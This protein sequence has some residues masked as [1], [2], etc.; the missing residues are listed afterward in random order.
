MLILLFRVSLM[1]DAYELPSSQP[2]KVKPL[3]I[4][5]IWSG[6]IFGVLFGRLF[7][8]SVDFTPLIAM[9]KSP[10]YAL[11]MGKPSK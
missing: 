7:G 10:G 4:E 2:P 11:G 5:M 6:T 8:R 3:L 9:S 1:C